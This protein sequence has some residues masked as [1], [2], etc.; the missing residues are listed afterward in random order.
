MYLKYKK[1]IYNLF[2]AKARESRF[3]GVLWVELDKTKRVQPQLWEVRLQ[4]SDLGCA[5]SEEHLGPLTAG[6]EQA[7]SSATQMCCACS[8]LPFLNGP[9]PTFE[10]TVR[11]SVALL[12]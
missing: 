10:Q 7:L 1:P 5:V 11:L 8:S 2:A 4:V 3:L 9:P 6:A 12:P